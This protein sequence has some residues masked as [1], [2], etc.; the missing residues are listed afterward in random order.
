MVE[1][2]YE[3]AMERIQKIKEEQTV[4][5]RFQDYFGTMSAFVVLIHEL[6]S[7]I[8]SGAYKELSLQELENWNQRLYGDVLFGKL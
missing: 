8:D 1:E 5:E 4:A 2:R 7:M 6:K 3:L